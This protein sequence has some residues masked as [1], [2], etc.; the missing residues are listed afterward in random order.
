[1]DPRSSDS[2]M[3]PISFELMGAS[4][5]AWLSGEVRSVPAN[6]ALQA[7]ITDINCG[8][9]RHYSAC[10]VG[11]NFVQRLICMSCCVIS[12]FKDVIR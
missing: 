4:L 5:E 2:F 1:M 10:I 8:V 9:F 12:S 11:Q 6:G 7:V 3:D